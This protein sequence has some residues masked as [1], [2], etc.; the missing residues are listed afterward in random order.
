MDTRWVRYKG[1]TVGILWVFLISTSLVDIKRYILRVLIC[2]NHLSNDGLEHFL[3][4][5]L[6]PCIY[7]LLWSVCLTLLPIFY[8]VV[9]FLLTCKNSLYIQAPSH[10]YIHI[11]SMCVCVCVYMYVYIH[12]YVLD[13]G[14]FK[15]QS[16][17]PQGCGTSPSYLY[18]VTEFFL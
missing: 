7:L 9:F 17:H 5:F 13:L 16:H 12:I 14:N 8:S 1:A 10:I 4:C 2:L 11:Y 15:R 3:M 18:L 6:A